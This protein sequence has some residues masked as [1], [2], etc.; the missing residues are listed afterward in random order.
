MRWIRH[1][2]V[3]RSARDTV[4]KPGR[5]GRDGQWMRESEVARLPSMSK[6]LEEI[7]GPVLAEV[8]PE[9]SREEV[10]TVYRAAALAWNMSTTKSEKLAS[11]C[12]TLPADV[13]RDVQAMLRRKERLYGDDPRMVL[14]VRTVRTLDGFRTRAASAY[15]D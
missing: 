4:G 15:A 7:A 14:S 13:Q 8:T 12:A 10:E 1:G 6:L 9:W 5:G 3:E 11:L 2:S